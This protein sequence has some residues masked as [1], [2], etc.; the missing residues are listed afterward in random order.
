MEARAQKTSAWN[1]S[2]A[3]NV[4]IAR[5]AEP[6]VKLLPVRDMDTDRQS[7]VFGK[8]RQHQPTVTDRTTRSRQ[9]DDRDSDIFRSQTSLIR[10]LPE[11]LICSTKHRYRSHE[12]T[13]AYGRMP[14]VSSMVTN[15]FAAT[16]MNFC[17]VPLGHATSIELTTGSRPRPNTS[18]RSL[19]EA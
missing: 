6:G 12:A 8:F 7:S 5:I 11:I 14:R 16:L 4:K 15:R 1:S 18:A 19:C 2:L 10:P 9:F 13:R 17:F 3:W